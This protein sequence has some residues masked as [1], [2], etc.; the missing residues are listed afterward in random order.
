MADNPIR[1]DLFA[2]K[3][4]GDCGDEAAWCYERIF[5]QRDSAVEYRKGILALGLSRPYP[6]VK[7]RIV[8]PSQRVV[9]LFLLARNELW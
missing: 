7:P 3:V 4:Y 9:D 2:V 8:H 5:R 1:R 6:F